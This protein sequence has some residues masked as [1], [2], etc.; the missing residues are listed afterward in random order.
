MNIL[1]SKKLFKGGVLVI[2]VLMA[3]ALL[4]GAGEPTEPVAAAQA[5]QFAVLYMPPAFGGYSLMPHFPPGGIRVLHFEFSV[6][7]SDNSDMMEDP[8]GVRP[9]FSEL[10]L[11]KEFDTASPDLNYHCAAGTHY[12]N[13]TLMVV[14]TSPTSPPYYIITLEDVVIAKVRSRMV[15]STGGYAHLEEVSLK[16]GR[17]TW[18]MTGASPTTW[19]LVHNGVEE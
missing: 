12:A 17:V 6:T 2:A 16:C 1:K 10:T 9:R 19:D 4:L 7:A 3:I 11:T 15:Y 8:W 5:R 14:L 18:D 13:A